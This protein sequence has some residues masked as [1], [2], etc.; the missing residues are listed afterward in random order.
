[1]KAWIVRDLPNCE[2]CAIVFAETRG[3]AIAYCASYDDVI[4]EV[5]FTN[6]EARRA[7]AFDGYYRGNLQ[8][9]WYDD[10]DRIAM[11]RDAGF[12]C[13]DECFDPAECD[14]CSAKEWCGQYE[15]YKAFYSG[16]EV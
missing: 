11:V 10:A 7:K 8:M 5:A 4:G 16:L 2:F 9:D 14:G 13:N 15:S 3:K 6:V 1:M 12:Q